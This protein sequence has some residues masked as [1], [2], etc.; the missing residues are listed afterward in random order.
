MK[1][2][3]PAGAAISSAK[4]A[5]TLRP[6]TRLMTSPTSQPNVRP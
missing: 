6:D 1:K 3:S 5:P 2:S 4:N